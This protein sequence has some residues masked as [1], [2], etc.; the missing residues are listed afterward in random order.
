[1]RGLLY[2]VA[3]F[4]A[5]V[6][7]M[8]W[9]LAVLLAERLGVTGASQGWLFALQGLGMMLSAGPTSA[10]CDRFGKRVMVVASLGLMVLAWLL[11]A[12]HCS[13]ATVACAQVLTGMSTASLT[14]ISA[15]V[16]AHTPEAARAGAFARMLAARGVGQILGP[17]LVAATLAWGLPAVCLLLTGLSLLGV[18]V[19]SLLQDSRSGPSAAPPPGAPGQAATAWLPWAVV[20]PLLAM[21]LLYA[22]PSGVSAYVPVHAKE[23]FGAS[24]E[25]LAALFS[26]LGLTMVL[27]PA[28]LWLLERC[29]SESRAAVASY[30]AMALSVVAMAV[31]PTL[32]VLVAAYFTWALL[33]DVAYPYVKAH[34][35]RQVPDAQQTRVQAAEQFTTGSLGLFVGPLS[36]WLYQTA[37]AT[38]MFALAATLSLLGVAL[39]AKS[40]NKRPALVA[41]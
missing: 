16:G 25:S 6:V 22:T 10:G 30:L 5:L 26:L 37:G 21:V 12:L 3:G 1:M 32:S 20:V 2:G 19:A 41:A 29:C 4:N 40:L 7:S 35:S 13:Y 11:V 34:L 23:G 33:W 18:L 15:Y 38:P 28:V 31:A 36:G 24:A 8:T 9:P 27:A 14:V 17:L 39:L